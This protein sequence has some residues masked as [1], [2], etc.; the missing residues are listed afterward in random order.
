MNYCNIDEN[1]LISKKEVSQQDINYSDQIKSQLKKMLT[2]QN[3]NKVITDKVKT[4]YNIENVNLTTFKKKALKTA[5]DNKM[6]SY[7]ERLARL[8]RDNL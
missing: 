3:L 8:G 5:E 6:E 7:A 1:I 2:V 4:F